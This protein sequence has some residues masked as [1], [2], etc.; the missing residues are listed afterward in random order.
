MAA[1]AADEADDPLPPPPVAHLNLT[2]P[3]TAAQARHALNAINL[4]RA[5]S[6][7]IPELEDTPAGPSNIRR[8]MIHPFTITPVSDTSMEQTPP[9]NPSSS[10]TR[11]FAVVARGKHWSPMRYIHHHKDPTPSSSSTTFVPPTT[12]LHSAL[13]AEARKALPIPDT[14]V[15]PSQSGAVGGKRAMVEVEMTVDEPAARSASGRAAKRRTLGKSEEVGEEREREKE[16]ERERPG[17]RGGR[18]HGG[19]AGMGSAAG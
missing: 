10:P 5:A 13:P 2:K 3:R 8:P 12:T 7:P 11:S 18:K 1:F 17:R 19:G 14:G 9:H 6:A 15:V 4:N 16:R